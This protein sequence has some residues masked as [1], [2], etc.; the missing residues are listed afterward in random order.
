LSAELLPRGVRVNVVSPGPIATPLYGKLG[1]DKATLDTTAAQIQSQ[2][3]VGRFGTPEELASTIL[4]ISAAESAFIVG[5]EI[6]VDGGMSQ[7]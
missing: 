1:M 2:V 4:H 6:I 3:P 7:L 5:T